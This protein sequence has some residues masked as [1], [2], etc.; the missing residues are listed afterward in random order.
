MGKRKANS[1]SIEGSLGGLYGIGV[2]RIE[3]PADSA[4]VTALGELTGRTNL[5]RVLVNQNRPAA[6]TCVRGISHVLT[7]GV[8]TEQ[9]GTAP[10]TSAGDISHVS[11]NKVP[12][13][14]VEV[15]STSLMG[16][17]SQVIPIGVPV[18]PVETVLA[19]V[20]EGEDLTTN[21]LWDLLQN[22]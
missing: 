6:A 20:G 16:G 19:S 8:P 5:R 13:G 1:D 12:V 21:H 7:T 2:G 15:D 9:L 11:F 14:Q 17:G 3:V 18:V 22:A 10:A 4:P